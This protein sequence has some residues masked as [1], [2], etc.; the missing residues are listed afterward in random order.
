MFC[1]TADNQYFRKAAERGLVFDGLTPEELVEQRRPYVEATR[2]AYRE[3]W[4]KNVCEP[5]QDQI[6]GISR[7]RCRPASLS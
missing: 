5:G 4:E 1:N 3:F 6:P 7:L 2:A